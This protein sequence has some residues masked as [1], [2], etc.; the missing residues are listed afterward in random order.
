MCEDTQK[1]NWITA[2]YSWGKDEYIFKIRI[3]IFYRDRRN[4]FWRVLIPNRSCILSHSVYEN[5]EQ[6]H[7]SWKA[8]DSFWFQCNCINSNWES[9]NE[10]TIFIIIFVDS[11]QSSNREKQEHVPKCRGGQGPSFPAICDRTRSK[12]RSH[13]SHLMFY[14]PEKLI[15][16][17]PCS[18]Y[19]ILH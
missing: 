3:T 5:K 10:G 13:Y 4:K 17:P 1:Y 19:T 16:Y 8:F 11:L 7:I 9:M 15:N 2:W 18:T 6:T 14:Q 12:P